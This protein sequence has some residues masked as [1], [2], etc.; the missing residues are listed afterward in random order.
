VERQ[1][2][3]VASHIR[4]AHEPVHHAARA[5][6]R[7]TQLEHEH[8]TGE[9]DRHPRSVERHREPERWS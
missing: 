6:E 9:T 2:H 8:D 1:K 7:R 5:Y 3:G 4:L